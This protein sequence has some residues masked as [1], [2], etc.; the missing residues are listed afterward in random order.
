MNFD[1]IDVAIIKMAKKNVLQ[2]DI[3]YRLHIS[4]D[5][6]KTRLNTIKEYFIKFYTEKYPIEE[7]IDLSSMENTKVM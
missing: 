5:E 1:E 2:G 6:L 7:E 4:K 3:C